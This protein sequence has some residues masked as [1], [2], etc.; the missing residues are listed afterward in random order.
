MVSQTPVTQQSIIQWDKTLIDRSKAKKSGT[1][2]KLLWD[3]DKT[4]WGQICKESMLVYINLL[5]NINIYKESEPE[6]FLSDMK[7]LIQAKRFEATP[8]KAGFQI[9]SFLMAIN[10]LIQQ[11]VC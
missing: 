3:E 1:V 11:G 9:Q 6:K 8:S 10:L 5:I 4:I 2:L 7:A